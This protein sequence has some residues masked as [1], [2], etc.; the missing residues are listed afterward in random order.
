MST[1]TTP[2]RRKSTPKDA[3]IASTDQRSEISF[4]PAHLHN[5]GRLAILEH[6]LQT[7]ELRMSTSHKP[8]VNHQHHRRSLCVAPQAM[9]KLE[10]Q[11]PM[12]TLD[13]GIFSPGPPPWLPHPQQPCHR[14]RSPATNLLDHQGRDTLL[15][16][17]LASPCTT[18][19]AT[20]SS[21]AG[22]QLSHTADRRSRARSLD[23]S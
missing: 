21:T 18:P 11:L 10:P 4:R 19:S 20:T 15:L 13:V 9:K 1:P 2:S 23:P 16:A 7:K 17:P 6:N 14:N 12:T 22:A 5:N 8:I 3:T